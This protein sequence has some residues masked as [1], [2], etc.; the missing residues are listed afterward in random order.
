MC[1]QTTQGLGKGTG[2]GKERKDILNSTC[3]TSVAQFLPSDPGG[4]WESY[5]DATV[6]LLHRCHRRSVG[7]RTR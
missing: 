6:R 7:L 1:K 2:A 5:I 3:R 4:L